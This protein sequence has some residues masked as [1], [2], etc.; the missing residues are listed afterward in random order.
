MNKKYIIILAIGLVL[1][2]VLA[3]VYFGRSQTAGTT[4]IPESPSTSA[5]QSATEMPVASDAVVIENFAFSPA[6][7]EIQS[8]QKVVWKQN[9]TIPHTVVSANNLFASGTLRKGDEF[10]FVFSKA[11][12]YDYHC[13]IHPSM[14]GKIIVR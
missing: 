14:I 2:G 3:F 13:G 9:D 1:A 11:G 4:Y 12:E 6:T 7:L 10:S 5:S 8:G